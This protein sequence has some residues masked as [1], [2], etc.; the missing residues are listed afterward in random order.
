MLFR[1]LASGLG[2]WTGIL[3][4]PIEPMNSIAN[5]LTDQDVVDKFRASSKGA[6]IRATKGILDTYY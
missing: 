2:A 5:N 6:N 1:L 4:D 3:D